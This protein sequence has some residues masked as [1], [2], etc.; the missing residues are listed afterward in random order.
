M[1]HCISCTPLPYLR[2]DIIHDISSQ[3]SYMYSLPLEVA[4]RAYHYL[5]TARNGKQCIFLWEEHIFLN[6]V[7]FKVSFGIAFLGFVWVLDSK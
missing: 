1:Y 6:E 4:R 7:F 3:V 2:L 5:S